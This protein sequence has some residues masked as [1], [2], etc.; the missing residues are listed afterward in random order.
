M[1]NHTSD[2]SNCTSTSAIDTANTFIKNTFG[3]TAY[4][5]A[6]PNGASTCNTSSVS[7][8]FLTNRSVNGG[9]VSA[10]DTSSFA[11]LPSDIATT[12]NLAPAAGKWRIICIH[13]F[14]GG[15]DG[16]YQPIPLDS[17]TSAAKA[18]VSGGAWVETVTNVAA[19]QWGQKALSGKTTSATWTKPTVFPPNT[20]VRITTAG[21]T[22]TQNGQVVPWDDHGYYEISL[23]A[24]SVTI[25]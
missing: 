20:C 25:Q 8:K 1:G 13:G 3:V 6:A 2:H 7:S 10:G 12:S 17:F 5:F 15:T 23:D 9:S 18:A 14:T 11:W 24:G 16:A 21:G 4:A 22:V 19:Y